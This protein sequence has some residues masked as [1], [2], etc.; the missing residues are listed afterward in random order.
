MNTS[1]FDCIRET[2]LCHSFRLR[3]EAEILLEHLLQLFLAH[4]HVGIIVTNA[5]TQHVVLQLPKVPD[6][7][8]SSVSDRAHHCLPEQR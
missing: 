5:Q 7:A 1:Q 6:P 3:L 8:A 4:P 2:R